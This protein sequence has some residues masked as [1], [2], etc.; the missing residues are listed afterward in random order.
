MPQQAAPYTLI[1]ALFMGGGGA[2]FFDLEGGGGGGPFLALPVV[3]WRFWKLACLESTLPCDVA[4][5]IDRAPGER[6][7]LVE[8][9]VDAS[10]GSLKTSVWIR[11]LGRS[12]LRTM[13][14]S[15]AKE[16]FRPWGVTSRRI[17]LGLTSRRMVG[18]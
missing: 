4:G 9:A 12:W 1:S 2:G 5:E 15:L 16:G 3:P 7:G 10:L 17:A 6:S 8:L 11:L 14:A 18:P 13:L